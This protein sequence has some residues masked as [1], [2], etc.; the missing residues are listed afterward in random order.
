[1]TLRF[2]RTDI[3]LMP[4]EHSALGG[5]IFIC[6]LQKFPFEITLRFIPT[7]ITLMTVGTLS[8]R[9]CD[10]HLRYVEDCIQKR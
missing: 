3:N 2:I 9:C 7:D 6:D 10:F 8:P 4:L 1:M 5:V